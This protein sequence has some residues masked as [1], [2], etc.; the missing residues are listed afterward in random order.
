M[1]LHEKSYFSPVLLEEFKILKWSYGAFLAVTCT[2]MFWKANYLSRLFESSAMLS[3][4]SCLQTKKNAWGAAIL[5]V[6]GCLEQ[7]LL[8]LTQLSFAQQCELW[9]LDA[10]WFRGTTICIFTWKGVSVWCMERGLYTAYAVE[11][12]RIS[13]IFPR[14]VDVFPSGDVPKLATIWWCP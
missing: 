10:R 11:F 14:T 12:W 7:D 4:A 3:V 6:T 5:P 9:Y 2:R 8:R 1:Y 13:F